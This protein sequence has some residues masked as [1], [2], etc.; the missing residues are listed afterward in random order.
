MNTPNSPRALTPISGE[1]RRRINQAAH[2]EGLRHEVAAR[3]RML[4]ELRALLAG[5]AGKD[6]IGTFMDRLG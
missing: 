3:D 1:A 6:E 4:R 5:G 2:A